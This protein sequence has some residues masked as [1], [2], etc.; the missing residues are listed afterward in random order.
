MQGLIVNNGLKKIT[1][2][3]IIGYVG[4]SFG[5]GAQEPRQYSAP[6][7]GRTGIYIND[8]YINLSPSDVFK[9]AQ[10]PQ[11]LVSNKFKKFLKNNEL[12]QKIKAI[13]HNGLDNASLST[14]SLK[15]DI[16]G[17]F[18]LKQEVLTN[19][20]DNLWL[21]KVAGGVTVGAGVIVCGVATQSRGKEQVGVATMG[22][23]VTLAGVAGL[24]WVSYQKE[25]L[26]KHIEEIQEMNKDWKE[27]FVADEK[28]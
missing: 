27:F 5:F 21:G 8:R 23:I 18:V 26:D 25:Y 12:M 16:N 10:N 15:Q 4:I 20:R 1:S 2:L 28:K 7:I 3:M 13:H 6:E 22:A 19:R 17:D 24:Y 14:I 11:T 9:K